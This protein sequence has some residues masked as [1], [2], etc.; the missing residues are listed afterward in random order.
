M[1]IEREICIELNH[2]SAKAHRETVKDVFIVFQDKPEAFSYEILVNDC[3][4]LS[5]GAL[6][7]SNFYSMI[8]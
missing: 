5:G 6:Q 8:L 1:L 2:C 4:M 3:D 7:A